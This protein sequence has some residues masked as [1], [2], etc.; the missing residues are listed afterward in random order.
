MFHKNDGY[1][2][3]FVCQPTLGALEVK[4]D[5]GTD[6]ILS[7]K[8]KGGFNS[9]LNPPRA[10][11]LN[12]IKLSGYRIGIK[13]DKDLLVA[14]ENN[15]LSKVVHVYIVFDLDACPR[16]PNNNFKFKNWLFGATNIVKNSDKEM[17]V[18]SG[19]RITFDS[20]CLCSFG[21]DYYGVDNSS[22][23]HADDNYNNNFSCL[24]KVQLMVLMESSN[25]QKKV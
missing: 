4:K 2:N 24:V 10:A 17:Y 16:N 8:S 23:S 15:G 20:A 1:Q 13:F 12:S 22:S 11:F 21:N 5:K 25:C 3:T 14:E 9:K 6:Y 18:Y 7:S 19:F